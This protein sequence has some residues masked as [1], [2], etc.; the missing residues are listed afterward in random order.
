MGKK[1]KR[2]GGFFATG[3]GRGQRDCTSF[4]IRPGGGDAMGSCDYSHTWIYT[5]THTH[6]HTHNTHR[7]SAQAHGNV[8]AFAILILAAVVVVVVVDVVVD[9]ISISG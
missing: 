8:A 9:V 7:P 3:D 4:G 1:R 2:G 5:D 6:T